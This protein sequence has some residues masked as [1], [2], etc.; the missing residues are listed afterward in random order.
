M[1]TRVRLEN[2]KAYR[3]FEIALEPGTTFLVAPNGVGKSSFLDAVR[4]V[5]DQHARPDA[6]LMR[7]TTKST[8]VEVDL[9]VGDTS[10]TL[11]RSMVAG[12]G[13]VPK[14]DTEARKDG[15]AVD[16]DEAY[17]T[18]AAHWRAEND[19]MLRAAF[20]T[21]RFL[22]ENPDLRAHLVRLHGLDN[23]QNAIAALTPAARQALSDADDAR[24]GAAATAD[25]IAQAQ[26]DAFDAAAQAL[27]AG[28]QVETTKA[29]HQMAK[30][31]LLGARAAA[32]ALATHRAWIIRR[33]ELRSDAEASLGVDLASAPLAASLRAAEDGARRQLAEV[34]DLRARLAERLKAVD[35][36]LERLAEATAECPLC[37]QSLD[38]AAR[39]R[40]EHLHRHDHD[41]TTQEL[42]GLD[43]ETPSSVIGR[44]SE[45]RERADALGDEPAVPN[46][47]GPALEE[48]VRIEA[49][50][51]AAWETA[52]A[53]AGGAAQVSRDAV[54]TLAS[55]EET[56]AVQSSDGLYARAAML[57]AAR[58]AL[59]DTITRVLDAQIGPVAE[60][61][62]RRWEAVFPDRPGLRIGPDGQLSR[63]FDDED[64]DLD[65]AQFSAGEQMVSKL[66]LRLATLTAT[67]DIPFCWIDEPL[68]HLD[69]D[70]R[71]YVA[72][73]L[74]FMTRTE[75]LRQIF[76]TTYEE[77][78]AIHLT[79]AAPE[80]V[81][82]IFLHAAPVAS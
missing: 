29:E 1:I 77:P 82:L 51:A 52:V 33:D 58:D 70:A 50:A 48:A 7:R 21:D 80:D 8:V 66:L 20:L 37:R 6:A 76:V 9:L 55:L 79:A 38:E 39:A 34:R 12:R 43:L 24:K 25:A 15:V 78:L 62:N 44:I 67:T 18:L 61:V 23:A 73:T 17:A 59:A 28:A 27:H 3:S 13:K 30:E 4:W 19:F 49:E 69:P 10:Y 63:A 57:E 45:L 26:T 32:D 65:F 41:M 54:A 64:P 53:D 56:T 42:N 14:M 40:A 31:L 71:R 16:V 36:A 5:L 35:D 11:R 22:D 72:R 75:G 47:D 2:W 46:H 68:E 60:E 74:A 81:R